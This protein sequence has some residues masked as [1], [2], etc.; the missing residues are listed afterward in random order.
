MAQHITGELNSGTTQ[1]NNQ[2][3]PWSTTQN[4]LMNYQ[5]NAPTNILIQGT[6]NPSKLT[7]T[8]PTISAIFTDLD[9]T[10]TADYYEIEINT[11]AA[12]DGTSMWGH[13][14]NRNICN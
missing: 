14:E 9:E 2:E 1:P 12:F 7:D 3:S 4:F 11:T 5:P 6:Y 8:T 10:G 13:G